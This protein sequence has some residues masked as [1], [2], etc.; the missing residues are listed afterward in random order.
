MHATIATNRP[1]FPSILTTR[2]PAEDYWEEYAPRSDSLP[3]L[4]EQL[5]P[6]DGFLVTLLL[7]FQPKYGAVVDLAATSTG[8][9]STALVLNHPSPS[10]I[11]AGLGDGDADQ[12]LA[13]ALKAYARQ[14]PPT[15]ASLM[16]LPRGEMPTD[17]PTRHGVVV[18]A[19][20][21]AHTPEALAELTARW[22]LAY[23]QALLL[24]LG[25][26]PVADS[27]AVAALLRDC[28]PETGRRFWLARELAEALASSHLAV[29]ARRDHPH[30]D[31]DVQRLRQLYTG[32]VRYLDLL[33]DVNA[34]AIRQ[35]G[36]DDE[37]MRTHHPTV[38]PVLNELS[39]WKRKS[40]A[41]S[42]ELAR[43]RQELTEVRQ[44]PGVSL[45]P[46][47]AEQ[48]WRDAG[49]QSER[50][51]ALL[52]ATLAERDSQIQAMQWSLAYRCALRVRRLRLLLAPDQSR[53][54]WLLCRFR[55]AAQIWRA[56][57]FRSLLKRLVAKRR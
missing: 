26:G 6:L 8:G 28:T 47:V 23:P 54:Y 15:G 56:E 41:A 22:L 32:N 36:A 20:A 53:R 10:R 13:S 52:R 16:I 33:W 34:A 42:D 29:V 3:D 48:Q 51:L 30:A 7:G 31:S 1:R 2:Q 21:R 44:T 50:Q 11:L 37:A 18:V 12:K 9:A 45:D 24:L 46:F 57:G 27:G 39:E 35:A 4:D 49:E 5:P 40:L 19:N 38:A 25:V 17:L 55:R 14:L 43:L